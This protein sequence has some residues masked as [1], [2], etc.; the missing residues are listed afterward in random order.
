ME[1]RNT[2]GRAGERTKDPEVNGNPTG[3]PM[4]STYLDPWELSESESLT[5]ELTE[6][7]M[8]SFQAHK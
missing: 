7:G 1:D 4:E 3:R 8:A 5:K 6:T 2:Y